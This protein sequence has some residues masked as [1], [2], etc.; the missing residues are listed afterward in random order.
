M[1]TKKI[2]TDN[3][4]PLQAALDSIENQFGEGSIFRMGDSACIIP[5][6]VSTGSLSL[7]LA[8]GGWGVPRGRITEIFGPESSGKTTL[9]LHIIANAQRNNGTVAYID[10][11][12]AL[13][14][15]WANKVGVDTKAMLLSQP[16]TGEEALTIVE[17]L[18]KSNSV[19]V[20]VVDSVAALTPKAELEGEMGD[21]HIGLQARLM[22]QA[23]RKLAALIGNSKTALIFINQIRMKIGIM[24]GNP[25]TTTGGKALKFYSSVRIDLRKISTLKDSLNVIGSHIRAKVVKNK[26]APPFKEAEFDILFASGI[27]YEGDIIDVALSKGLITKSGGWLIYGEI[28]LHGREGFVKYLVENPN[29]VQ[30]LHNNIIGLNYENNKG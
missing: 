22:S 6:G 18:I 9:A 3:I 11:E 17:T 12:H 4:N 7:N 27:S 5:E 28:K 2:K 20:I 19:D 15:T 10:A 29:L 16:N 1:S 25:E 26:I 30:E 23:M 21:C 24:F 8:L 14:L 13:D